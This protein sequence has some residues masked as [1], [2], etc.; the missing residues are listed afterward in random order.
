M[1]HDAT[2]S[3]T[4]E[5]GGTAVTLEPGKELAARLLAAGVSLEVV[6]ERAGIA[7]ATLWRWRQ[8]ADFLTRLQELQRE[9]WAGLMED[10]RADA[11][12]AR[13]TLREILDDPEAPVSDRRQT[14][15]FLLA[16]YG[17]E[18]LSEVEEPPGSDLSDRE[19]EAAV[20]MALQ[21]PEMVA[22]LEVIR[23]VALDLAGGPETP[24]LGRPEVAE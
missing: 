6:A 7:R 18:G 17:P 19:L 3:N 21:D 24:A 22:E 5:A 15:S 4:Q 2:D 1:K 20:R 16:K 12:R 10:L 23:R 11:V 9:A 14:A 8:R 13:E